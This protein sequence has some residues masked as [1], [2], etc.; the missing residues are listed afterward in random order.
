MNNM[1]MKWFVREVQVEDMREKVQEKIRNKSVHQK[2][3]QCR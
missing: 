3:E 1:S 2:W